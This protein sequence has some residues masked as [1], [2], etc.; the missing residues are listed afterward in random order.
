VSIDDEG[1]EERITKFVEVQ[2]EKLRERC[3]RD[4]VLSTEKKERECEVCER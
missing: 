3:E 1:D 2:F 4:T